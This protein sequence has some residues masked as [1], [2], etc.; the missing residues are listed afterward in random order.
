MFRPES[1]S[2]TTLLFLKSD[3]E[4]VLDLLNKHG[5]FHLV[6]KK[7][8]FELSNVKTLI[9]RVNNLIEKINSICFE[10]N[11]GVNNIT[12]TQLI[13]V[14]NWESLISLIE[15]KINEY[16]NIIKEIE[17]IKSI[18]S[19]LKSVIS[20]WKPFITSIEKF[21]PKLFSSKYFSFLVFYQKE[22]RIVDLK[23]IIP[24][25]T[26]VFDIVQDPHT[27]FVICFS[28]EVYNIKK[29]FEEAGYVE[30]PQF[31][32]M[33][34]DIIEASK[35]LEYFEKKFNEISSKKSQLISNLYLMKSNLEYF[36]SL[37]FDTYTIFSIK[38]SNTLEK[39]WVM[40]EGYVPTKNVEN[41]LND[42]KNK[43]NGRIIFNSIEEHSS[44]QVPVIFNYPKFFKLFESVTNLYGVP[45]YTEINPTPILAITFPLFFGLMFGDLG[46]GIMLAL[47]GL[48]MYKFSK[49]MEKIGKILIICG[50][51]SA[52]IGGLLYGEAF[53]KHIGY[54]TI[55]SPSEDFMSIFKFSLYIGAAQISLGIIIQ[56]I[57]N[58]IQKK[59]I[60]A[61]LFNLPRLFIYITFVYLVFGYG[62]NIMKWLEGPIF[63]L[64]IPSI[65]MLIGKPIFLM[66]THDK[67][68]GLSAFGE[69]SFEV[70]DTLIRSISNTA[71]YLRIFAMVMAHTLLVNVFYL[72]ASITGEGILGQIISW[73]I[74][75]IGNIF[76]V[77]LEGVIAIAQDL[78]LHFYEWFSK[79]YEDG[80]IKFTPFKLALGIPIIK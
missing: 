16:E 7:S 71:S 80:G 66:I 12:S 46:H 56:I 19:S 1:M 28:Q 3:T 63:L 53:G 10:E 59:K 31:D 45:S 43:L 73:L 25:P 64:F 72:L 5:A 17:L 57:N 4:Y 11:I 60:D 34:K 51:F 18:E 48:F 13:T 61:L 24:F 47:L 8:N 39:H 68:E 77:L 37:L 70:L 69:T 74:M 58:F 40:L 32:G 35:A 62:L 30:M 67:R 76:V 65:I 29:A 21:I 38:E 75:A 52:I 78:R 55:F 42:L 6:F 41:L 26:I 49:S 36:K 20:I 2:K 23:T 44:S 27:I 50:I 9:N 22:K 15:N 54:H 79:F 14:N 33:P